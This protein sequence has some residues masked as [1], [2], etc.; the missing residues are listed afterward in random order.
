MTKTYAIA[1]LRSVRL[2]ADIAEYLRRIDAT[3]EPFGGRFLVHGMTHEVLEGSWPGDLIIVEFPDRASAENWYRSDA[4]QSILPLRTENAEG[5]V[6][7]VDG[8]APDHKGADL[9]AAL[10]T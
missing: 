3:L 8:N 6:I 7:L 10:A 1:H 4:Y 2:G 5:S 9:L